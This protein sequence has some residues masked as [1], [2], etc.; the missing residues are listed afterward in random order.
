MLQ[1]IVDGLSHNLEKML[2]KND[3]SREV[4]HAIR[5]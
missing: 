2:A 3:A 1:S 5:S 4:E